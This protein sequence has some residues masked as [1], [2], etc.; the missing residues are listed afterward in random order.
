MSIII[1]VGYTVMQWKSIDVGYA[2]GVDN[3]FISG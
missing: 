3:H 1:I 2:A